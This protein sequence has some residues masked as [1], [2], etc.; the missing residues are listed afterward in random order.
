MRKKGT[1]KKKEN[2]EGIC[3]YRRK[4]MSKF[5]IKISKVR[6]KRIGKNYSVRMIIEKIYFEA[7]KKKRYRYKERIKD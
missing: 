4:G 7:K 1:L 5:V 3:K 2:I 6:T